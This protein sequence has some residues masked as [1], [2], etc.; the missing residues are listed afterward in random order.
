MEPIGPTLIVILVCIPATAVVCYGWYLTAK[1]YKGRLLHGTR[2]MCKFVAVSRRRWILVAAIVTGVLG[3]IFTFLGL[4]PAQ[5]GLQGFLIATPVVLMLLQP[6]VVLILANSNAEV[7]ELMVDLHSVTFPRRQ[8]SLLDEGAIAFR[9]DVDVTFKLSAMLNPAWSLRAVD[10]GVWRDRVQQLVELA[11]IVIVDTRV[12]T[13]FTIW[14]AALMLQP[15]QVK[16][17]I[18]VVGPREYAPTLWA[19]RAVGSSLDGARTVLVEDLPKHLQRR[20][21]S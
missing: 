17:A 15:P 20:L 7:F 18:F 6:P 9:A 19:H 11:P 3:P 4:L 8:V 2:Q 21:K 14:E 13:S 12:A 10:N 5:W 16:K 1:L